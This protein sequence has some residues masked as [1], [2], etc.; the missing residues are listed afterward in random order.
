[1]AL[2]DLCFLPVDGSGCSR[3]D[4]QGLAGKRPYLVQ[5]IRIVT[6]GKEDLHVPRSHAGDHVQGTENEVRRGR[7]RQLALTRRGKEVDG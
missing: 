7:E 2:T 6:G 1:M 5:W 4:S 3:R